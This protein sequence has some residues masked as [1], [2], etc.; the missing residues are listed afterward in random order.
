MIVSALDNDRYVTVPASYP[1]VVGVQ[2]DRE[3]YLHPGELAYQERGE[4]WRASVCELHV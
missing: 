3:Q 1:F 4:A 2:S